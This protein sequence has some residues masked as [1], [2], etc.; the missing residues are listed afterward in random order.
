MPLVYIRSSPCTF[1]RCPPFPAGVM[2]DR[3]SVRPAYCKV[4]ATLATLSEQRRDAS[5]SHREAETY[6]WKEYVL[7]G[8]IKSTAR[9]LRLQ[10]LSIHVVETFL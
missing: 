2:N 7:Y 4:Y 10:M 9:M 5:S 1:T 6:Q 8:S 3:I